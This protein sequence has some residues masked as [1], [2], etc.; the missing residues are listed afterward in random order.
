[1]SKKHSSHD[2]LE[3]SQPLLPNPEIHTPPSTDEDEQTPLS[4]TA[5]HGARPGF[6]L[7]SKKRRAMSTRLALV[8]PMENSMKRYLSTALP[9]PELDNIKTHCPPPRPQIFMP[10]WSARNRAPHQL[11]LQLT[12]Q[13]HP[14][15]ARYLIYDAG[16]LLNRPM[17]R[18]KNL[19]TI[20][21]YP[22]YP[23]LNT[24]PL[25]RNL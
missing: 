10:E 20:W 7:H 3:E 11:L 15:Q 24:Q 2:C 4:L 19:S 13:A 16:M 25:A 21:V 6:D 5:S 14:K 23:T 17:D 22:S 1:M 12:K 8:S 18:G 9:T